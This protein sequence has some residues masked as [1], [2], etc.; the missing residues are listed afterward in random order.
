MTLTLVGTCRHKSAGE[1]SNRSSTLIHEWITLTVAVAAHTQ[2]GGRTSTFPCAFMY[3]LGRAPPY[4]AG[5][6]P[7][8]TD[9]HVWAE[10]NFF[11]P[12]PRLFP[13]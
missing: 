13:A 5:K 9:T 2:S 8:T 4:C 6:E 11:T 1:D 10:P 7:P 12:S 3:C